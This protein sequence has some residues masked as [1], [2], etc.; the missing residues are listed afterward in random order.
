MKNIHQKKYHTARES[1]HNYFRKNRKILSPLLGIVHLKPESLLH[2]VYSDKYHKKKRDEK[3]QIKRFHLVPYARRI[4]ESM[5]FHQ[6]YLEQ[7]Q[8]VFIK[9]K[10]HKVLA[11][12]LVRYWGF[13]AIIDNKIRVKIVLRQVGEGQIHFWS[14]IPFWKTRYYK[15]V[16]YTDLSTGNLET[17]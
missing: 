4:I 8:K 1:A 11:T 16:T 13:V 10:K 6:E 9:E 3:Q 17:E 5:G 2:L 12:K 14:I 15:G 7:Y